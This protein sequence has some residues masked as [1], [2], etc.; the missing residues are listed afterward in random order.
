M[1][2]LVRGLNEG[3]SIDAT[4][5]AAVSIDLTAYVGRYVKFWGTEDFHFVFRESATATID[6]T[7][8][9]AVGSA[10]IPETVAGGFAGVHRVVT[11]GA[12]HL[13]LKGVSADSDVRI[14]PTSEVVANG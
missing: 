8:P 12:P 6:L 11:A 14:K 1:E 2:A 10:N 9:K 13:V 3:A 7:I 5:S 4:T